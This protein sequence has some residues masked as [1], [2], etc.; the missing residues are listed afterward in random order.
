MCP[1]GHP[2]GWGPA[3]SPSFSCDQCRNPNVPGATSHWQCRTYAVCAHRSRALTR[4]HQLQL[5]RLPQLRPEVRRR[6][7]ARRRRLRPAPDGRRAWCVSR[8][9]PLLCSHAPQAATPTASPRW[10]APP[11]AIPALPAVCLAVVCPVV[12][13][14]VTVTPPWAAP[15]A[16]TASPRWAVRPAACPVH[17]VSPRWAALPVRRLVWMCACLCV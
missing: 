10:A 16:A 5:G 13:P 14:A 1:R 2:C 4:R 11:V 6:R 3:P 15:L 7:H 12:C 9:P 8:S 17:T